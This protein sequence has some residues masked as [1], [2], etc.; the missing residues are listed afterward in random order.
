M[1]KKINIAARYILGIF[2]L[3]LILVISCMTN[4]NEIISEKISYVAGIMFILSAVIMIVLYAVHLVWMIKEKRINRADL[5]SDMLWG[6]VF[7]IALC[8]YD[9]YKNCFSVRSLVAKIIYL[10][11]FLVVTNVAGYIYIRGKKTEYRIFRLDHA[12]NHKVRFLA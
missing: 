3:L 10:V 4:E 8:A 11:V 5:K 9:I 6:I 2:L 12:R 1:K 7:L